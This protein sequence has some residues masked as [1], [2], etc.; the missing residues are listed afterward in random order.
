MSDVDT[1]EDDALLAALGID[2]DEPVAGGRSRN[3]ERIIA[4]F[5]EIVRF[6]EKN[7][8]LPVAAEDHDIF[9]RIY[10]IRLERI[11]SD[12]DCRRIAAEFDAHGLLEKVVKHDDV[13]TLDDD[14]LL[15]RLGV[16]TP[17]HDDIRILTHVRSYEDRKA[18]EEVADRK[19]CRDFKKYKPLFDTVKDELDRKIRVTR[20]FEKKAEIET[21]RYFIVFGQLAYVAE[22]GEFFTNEHGHR[23]SRLRVIFDNGT[24]SDLL[25]RSLQRALNKDDTGRRVTEPLAGPLF[26]DVM[27]D[28]DDESGTIYVLRS[29]S[30]HPFVSEHREL[31]HKIGVTGESVEKRIANA[32]HDSTYLLAEVEIVATYK[33]AN[34]NRHRLESLFHKVFASAKLDLTIADRFGNPV[35]PKEWFL[36]PLHVIDEAVDLLKNGKLVEYIYDTKTASMVQMK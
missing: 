7:G 8:R 1:D 35:K 34:I 20:P 31:V 9:E 29:R 28:D 18:A 25:M 27:S 24:E 15:D 32:V 17:N 12:E 26:G 10:A 23:D 19:Q 22:M 5:E 13:D 30:S 3:E 21:G 4:G 2:I 36:V 33:L 16:S 11:V 6:F 14:A